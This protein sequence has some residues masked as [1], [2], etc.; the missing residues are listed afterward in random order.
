MANIC[1][2]DFTIYGTSETEIM[3]LFLR[4]QEVTNRER[5]SRAILRALGCPEEVVIGV[6]GRTEVEDLSIIKESTEGGI[7]CTGVIITCSSAWGPCEDFVMAVMEKV[8]P[9]N[10]R[11]K[12]VYL[13]QESGMEVFINTDSSGHFYPECV[14]VE[15]C[16]DSGDGYYLTEYYTRETF[17]DF[18]DLVLDET[19]VTLSSYD[20]LH[21][22]SILKAIQE[23]FAKKR[24]GREDVAYISI[25][26]FVDEDGEELV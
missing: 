12:Y 18:A 24:E 20:D 11:A 1:D 7:V 16:D 17:E 8:L 26:I 9:R 2:N 25:N 5:T 3:H 14:R 19:G 10:T 23:G 6:D 13:A 4:L 15:I 22:H 21:D